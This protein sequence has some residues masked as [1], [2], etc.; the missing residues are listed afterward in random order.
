MDPDFPFTPRTRPSEAAWIMSPTERP[1]RERTQELYGASATRKTYA[2]LAEM[3]DT[4]LGHGYSV[5]ADATYL[6]REDRKTI[7]EV[8]TRRRLPALILACDAPDAVLRKRVR[9]RQRADRDA[10][11]AG[12]AVLD[13]QLKKREPP[14]NSEPVLTVR[15]DDRLDLDRVE[16]AIEAARGAA[17]K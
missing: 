14:E 3:A 16:S 9:R 8:A 4:A 5:I 12:I 15:T 6:N 13:L 11:D 2:L 7:L 10:S 1:S 17:R